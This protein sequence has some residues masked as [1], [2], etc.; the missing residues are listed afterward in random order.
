MQRN[1]VTR[2]INLTFLLLISF[3][4]KYLS[5]YLNPLEA[6]KIIAELINSY[7]SI[8]TYLNYDELINMPMPM[9][10]ALLKAKT[11]SMTKNPEASMGMLG[12][13]MNMFG[14]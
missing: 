4:E 1:H 9:V 10:E 8:L 11:Q 7:L 2:K 12:Q 6:R 3:F 14:R 13:L 5:Q